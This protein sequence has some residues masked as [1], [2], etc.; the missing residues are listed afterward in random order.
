MLSLFCLNE[1]LDGLYEKPLELGTKSELI[2]PLIVKFFGKSE[3]Y[4]FAMFLILHHLIA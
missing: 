1:F 4:F 3:K 2:K